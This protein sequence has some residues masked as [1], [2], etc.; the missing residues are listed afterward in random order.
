MAGTLFG[1]SRNPVVPLPERGCLRDLVQSMGG[2]PGEL[3]HAESRIPVTLWRIR[4][5]AT[6][7][8]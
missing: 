3:T 1:S 8:H 4:E 5:N 6:W 2:D 7:L